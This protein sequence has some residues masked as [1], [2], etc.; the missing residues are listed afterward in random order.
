MYRIYNLQLILPLKVQQ[1]QGRDLNL[2]RIIYEHIRRLIYSF[3]TNQ[4]E[5]ISQTSKIDNNILTIC[6]TR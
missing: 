2:K 1:N 6:D 3:G 5:A 4:R